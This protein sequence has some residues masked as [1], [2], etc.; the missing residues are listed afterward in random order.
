MGD[1]EDLLWPGGADLIFNHSIQAEREA[2]LS[3]GTNTAVGGAQS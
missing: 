1:G 3:A 2:I